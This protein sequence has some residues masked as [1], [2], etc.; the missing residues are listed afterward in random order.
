M[1]I[2]CLALSL[3]LETRR[4]YESFKDLCDS[5]QPRKVIYYNFKYTSI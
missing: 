2:K 4:V 3:S 1:N 5:E